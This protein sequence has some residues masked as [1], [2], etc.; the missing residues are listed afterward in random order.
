MHVKNGGLAG[1]H[2]F[3]SH[4]C[5]DD[6]DCNHNDHETM[7]IRVSAQ[8]GGGGVALPPPR[9]T[10]RMKETYPHKYSN[11]KLVQITV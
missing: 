7:P 1:R 10:D 4:R 9:C 11:L 2:P 6:N 5:R 3:R 8:G